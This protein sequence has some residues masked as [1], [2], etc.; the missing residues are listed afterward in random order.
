M[1]IR[2]YIST[3]VF[4]IFLIL[5]ALFLLRHIHLLVILLFMFISL[6]LVSVSSVPYALLLSTLCF[7]FLN[8]VKIGSFPATRFLLLVFS[9][10]FHF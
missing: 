8:L 2:P 6:V 3:A 7:N 10:M 4:T 1:K 5:Q 9:F